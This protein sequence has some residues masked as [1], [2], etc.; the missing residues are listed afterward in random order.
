MSTA[1]NTYLDSILAGQPRLPEGALDWVGELRRRALERAAALSVPTTRDEEYRFTDLSPLYKLAFRPAVESGA[2]PAARLAPFG[3]AE[4]AVRLA[5]VDGLFAPA[6]STLGASAGLTVASLASAFRSHDALLRRALGSV[7]SADD[8][9]FRAINLAHLHDGALVHVAR[10]AALDAPV[11]LLFVSTTAQVASHP[12]VLVVAET[13]SAVTV[14]EDYVGLADEPYSVNG[15]AEL[16][17]GANARV[18][19]VRVQREGAAAFHI[20]TCAARVER[21][22]RLESTSIAF[23]ARISRLNLNVELAGEG[24]S[25][26]L[27][28][29]A[30]LRERQLADT[31]SLVDHAKPHGTSR[32]LHK[33]VAGGAA[34]GVFNGKILVRRGAQL[35]DS[36]QQSRNL[37]LSPRAHVDTKPQLDIF[38]DDVKAAHG[39]TVGQL[40]ADELFYLQSRGI[41]EAAARNLL[42]YG[43]AAEIVDR[44]PV[45][46]IAKALRK[47]VLEATHAKE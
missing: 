43:F 29:L 30:F 26:D 45:P 47:T 44:I 39:A 33:C 10:D 3:V 18:R 12:R 37:L 4:A 17:V 7:A 38:A 27:N 31:H 28:G 24:A 35:T 20:A 32:Q 23:G 42:T 41:D 9:A 22:A 13:G 19:H 25:V 11:H 36:A 16:I 34:H 5:F 14:I 46:S 6:L 21:D 8:D 1:A 15:V 40:D 2:V